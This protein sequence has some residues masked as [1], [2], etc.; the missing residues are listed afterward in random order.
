MKAGGGRGGMSMAQGG[1]V[2]SWLDGERRAAAGAACGTRARSERKLEVGRTVCDA[3]RT[4]IYQR[5]MKK[6]TAAGRRCHYVGIRRQRLDRVGLYNSV[7]VSPSFSVS[8]AGEVRAGLGFAS[9][10]EGGMDDGVLRTLRPA[11]N[12]FA[13]VFSVEGK[14]HGTAESRSVTACVAV[15]RTVAHS[16]FFGSEAT[17]VANVNFT[18]RT[19]LKKFTNASG[20]AGYEHFERFPFEKRTQLGNDEWRF[21]NVE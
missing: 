11:S 19:Q 21:S 12:P 8:Q 16:G 3:M 4:G 17:T 2:K 14:G 10:L 20:I 15:L 1:L 6:G 13:P 9:D 5:V 18:K 7:E